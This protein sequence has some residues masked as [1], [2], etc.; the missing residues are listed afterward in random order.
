[1]H[2]TFRAFAAVFFA[3]SQAIYFGQ[4]S[5]WRG[6]NFDHLIEV[7]YGDLLPLPYISGRH[8]LHHV[9]FALPRSLGVW[10]TWVIHPK[11]I[12]GVHKEATSTFELLSKTCDKEEEAQRKQQTTT[13]TTTSTCSEWRTLHDVQPLQ[14]LPNKSCLF[15]KSPHSFSHSLVVDAN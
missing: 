12:N 3:C 10:D 11:T 4:T 13:T 15:G 9:Q 1:M 2:K 8:K 14:V 6:K 7:A 5:S